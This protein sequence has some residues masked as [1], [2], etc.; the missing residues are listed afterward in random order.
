MKMK[1]L[2]FLPFLGLVSL[3]LIWSGCWG[4]MSQEDPASAIPAE[5]PVVMEEDYLEDSS[6]D[7]EDFPDDPSEIEPISSI[8]TSDVKVENGKF[9]FIEKDTS[10]ELV[11]EG[12][13]F[14]V[15]GETERKIKQKIA[16][17]EQLLEQSPEDQGANP[18]FGGCSAGQCFPSAENPGKFAVKASQ[19]IYLVADVTVNDTGDI[20]GKVHSYF[21]NPEKWSGMAKI[22]TPYVEGKLEGRILTFYDSP[23][24]GWNGLM[25]EDQWVNSES[26]GEL[27]SWDEEGNLKMKVINNHNKMTK[28]T[29]WKWHNNGVLAE[30]VVVSPGDKQPYPRTCWNEKSQEIDCTD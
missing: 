21:K 11:I 28:A 15:L 25:G 18:S 24:K 3:V 6:V 29:F 20:T 22:T 17:L 26:H 27:L 16:Q 10:E 1:K 14:R 13:R 2:R 8:D 30:E 12:E 19:E 9:V 23:D 5:A 7:N 4:E